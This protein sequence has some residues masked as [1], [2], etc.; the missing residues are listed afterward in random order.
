MKDTDA[1][2]A[3]AMQKHPSAKRVVVENFCWTAP[4]DPTAN[5][6]NLEMDAEMY[7]WNSDTVSAISFVLRQERKL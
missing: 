2:I 4:K 6:L 1:L 5:R 7:K 3:E